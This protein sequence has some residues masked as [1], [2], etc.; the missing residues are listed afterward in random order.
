MNF[1][2]TTSQSVSP[3]ESSACEIDCPPGFEFLKNALDSQAQLSC[4]TSSL[5]VGEKSS[6]QNSSSCNSG[7]VDDIKCILEGVETELHSS[8]K[9]FLS[10][11][12]KILVEDEVNKVVN[13]SKD[14]KSNEARIY[15]YFCSILKYF[16]ISLCASFHVH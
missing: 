14:K 4:I 5:A 11:Y 16:C 6:K 7:T 13:S 12:V 2:F 10:N 3:L 15:V 8:T 1:C 9:A